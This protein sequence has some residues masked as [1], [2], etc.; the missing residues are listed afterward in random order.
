[1][2][3]SNYRNEWA[4]NLKMGASGDHEGFVEARNAAGTNTAI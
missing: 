4:S 1:M 2:R 3:G